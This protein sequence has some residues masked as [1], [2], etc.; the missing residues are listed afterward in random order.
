MLLK[1]FTLWSGTP[2]SM[3]TGVRLP[4]LML[5]TASNYPAYPLKNKSTLQKQETTAVL[6][7]LHFN[8]KNEAAR[9]RLNSAIS[10]SVCVKQW[11]SPVDCS[12]PPILALGWHGDHRGLFVL[13]SLRP[14]NLAERWVH[15][16]PTPDNEVLITLGL[17]SWHTKKEETCPPPKPLVKGGWR[18]NLLLLINQ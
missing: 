13:L 3:V 12:P 7:R 16:T 17:L 2:G 10:S 6:K 5:S 1:T 15:H 9:D 14:E 4:L 8:F 18:I 11:E